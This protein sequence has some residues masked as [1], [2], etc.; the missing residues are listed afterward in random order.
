M[1]IKKLQLLVAMASLAFVGAANAQQMTGSFGVSDF[2]AGGSAS[3][4]TLTLFETAL[5]TSS[6]TGIFLT[7]VPAHSDL[8][9]YTNTISGIGSSPTT[10]NIS[11]YLVFSTPDATFGSSGT[12]PNNRFEF[13][14]AT[15]QYLGDGSG[16]YAFAGQGTL[17]DS[18]GQYANTPAEMTV[19]FSGPGTYSF[20]FAAEP[21]PEPSTIGLVAIGLLGVL[22]IRRRKV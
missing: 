11:D 2:Y 12:T 21:V 6:E 9:A 1:N 19:S 14:L 4:G 15:L 13:N 18:Q 17:V 7:L 10:E 16:T 5:I 8:T 22:M 20:S 3:A